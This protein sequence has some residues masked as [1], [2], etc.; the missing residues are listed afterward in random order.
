MAERWAKKTKKRTELEIL[1]MK[2]KMELFK[3][4]SYKSHLTSFNYNSNFHQLHQAII[5]F[6]KGNIQN[7]QWK[8]KTTAPIFVF[9][10]LLII[11]LAE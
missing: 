3:E 1:N 10:K 2:E 4:F 9:T 7:F 11:G 8:I 6:P 5:V